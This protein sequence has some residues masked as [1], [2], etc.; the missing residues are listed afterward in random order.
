[1][2][3]RPG[4]LAGR[5]P[6]PRAAVAT[7]TRASR[8]APS[9]RRPAARPG[10]AA[11]RPPAGRATA[12]E[13]PP[14]RGSSARPSPRL[15]LRQ[16]RCPNVG[17]SPAFRPSGPCPPTSPPTGS[18]PR[19]LAYPR[20][21]LPRPPGVASRRRSETPSVRVAGGGFPGRPGKTPLLTRTDAVTPPNPSV[22]VTG[23]VI[24]GQPGMES[25]S[26]VPRN[27]AV[28][29]SAHDADALVAT[30]FTQEAHRLVALARFFTDDRTAA[31]DLVQ[32]AFI[33]LGAHPPTGSATHD[34]AAAVPALDRHQ[35]RPRPQ[36]AR[37][38]L[39]CGTG[40]RPQP[41]APSA[42]EHA[43]EQA[44]AVARWST[45]LR[46]AAPPPARLPR[47]AL[48]PRPAGRARSRRPWACPANSVKTHLQ[49]GL[50]GPRPR[51]WRS[52]RW[53]AAWSTRL[54]RGR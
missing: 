34:R 41:D 49:R 3:A 28:S 15:S 51:T 11:R 33:R 45:A 40:R 53:T 35:P 27:Q 14:C 39:A 38:G 31:E 50:D 9:P 8:R 2:R 6:P 13:Q 20:S 21:I 12:A 54:R 29:G 5:R 10:C 18:V 43:A 23:G 37:A 25:V 16:S 44:R 1:M 7:R 48:L 42:E 47:T 32:E 17:R 19:R 36:P 26:A 52:T 24:P 46:R 4:G 22:R 30:L